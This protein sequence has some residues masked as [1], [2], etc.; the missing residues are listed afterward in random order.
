MKTTAIAPAE[1][2][3]DED[4]QIVVVVDR[5]NLQEI[6]STLDDVLEHSLGRHFVIHAADAPEVR[7]VLD[8]QN[9][10]VEYCLPGAV[11][12]GR[13]WATLVAQQVSKAKRTVFVRAGVR[14]PTAWDA[15]LV[16]AAQLHPMAAV[17]SPLLALDHMLCA[18]SKVQK[19]PKLSVDAVDQWL[20]DY[21]SGKVFSVPALPEA[22]LLLQGDYWQQPQSSFDSDAGLLADLR[23][24]GRWVVATDQLYVDDSAC[25]YSSG[26]DSFPEAYVAGFENQHPLASLRHALWELCTRAEIPDLERRCLPVQLHIGHSWGGGLNRWITNYLA[27]DSTHHHL[28]LRSIGDRT[29]FGQQIALYGSA[30]MQ[31]PLRT[32]VLAQ[33]ILSTVVSQLEYEQLL[34]EVIAQFNVESVVVSSFIGH[35][36]DSLRSGL[37]TTLVLHDFFPF[38]PALYACFG[39][40]CQSCDST[41]LK[42]CHSDNSL[43]S[44]F[45]HE[46]DEHWLSIRS[47]FSELLLELRPTI[48]APSQ[49]VLDRYAN[50]KSTLEELDP[51]VIPHGLDDEFADA[52]VSSSMPIP[53]ARAKLSVLVLGRM[54][55]E[56]GALLLQAVI[57]KASEF[58]EFFLLGAGEEG[59][60]FR[61]FDSCRVVD[62][63]QLADLPRYVTEQSPDIGLLL[64]VVP[65]TFSYTLSELWAM[66]I[67]VAATRLGAFSDRISE[68][69]N[70]WLVE[71]SADKITAKLE[72]ILTDRESLTRV[73][74]R[75]RSQTVHRS[76]SMVEAY[77]AVHPENPGI[78]LRRFFLPRRSFQNPY[79]GI[80]QQD[81]TLRYIERTH[82]VEATY[83]GVLREFLQYSAQKADQTQ[84]VPRVIRML[85][86]KGLS[87][88]AKAV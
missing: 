37:P 82:G 14:L 48:V 36:L 66:G 81:Q 40:P 83:R 49:S 13:F 15:R 19:E 56:K 54:T 57:P 25:H 45:R 74:N 32:W 34:A 35:S 73:S 26:V 3:L 1:L 69:D 77:N 29:A 20:N 71:P 78:P 10:P 76:S 62:D 60:Q 9:I 8:K 43:H 87:F 52:L 44:F 12:P 68:G 86:S 61:D 33:P 7:A 84:R 79:R 41:T 42:Q 80:E 85:L 46:P 22:C 11:E 27:A 75:V 16:A 59:E 64:S 67:P 55:A 53:E 51:L 28:V 50:L 39:S 23:G 21:A 65:E 5:E 24:K 63:Y 88:I 4:W 18:F 58:A 30:D 70:G 2:L 47:A 31:V 6:Q 17:V 72:D 38:C